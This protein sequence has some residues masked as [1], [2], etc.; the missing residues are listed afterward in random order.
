MNDEPERSGQADGE[1]ALT[2]EDRE[3]H[4][5]LLAMV[6]QWGRGH[7]QVK[8]DEDGPALFEVRLTVIPPSRRHPATA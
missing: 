1:P 3:T 4:E 7:V 5:R 2:Q 8:V 6:Q